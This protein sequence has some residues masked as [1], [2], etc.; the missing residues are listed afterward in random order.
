[1]TSDNSGFFV[2]KE[3]IKNALQNKVV[4]LLIGTSVFMIL[5]R[6][7]LPFLNFS[8][9]ITYSKDIDFHILY[10]GFQNGLIDFYKPIDFENLP[11]GVP[12]W[13][14]YYLYYWYFIFFPVAILPPEIGLYV[15]DILRI[16]F[17]CIV[18]AEA[19]KMFKNKNDRFMFYLLLFI[20][21]LIDVWYNNT[22]FLILF[23]MFLSYRYLEK[24]KF[25]ISGIFFM[26]SMYKVNS[27]LFLPVILL[28]RKVKL[29]QIYYY[30]VPLLIAFI[31]YF[32][33]PD[34]LT[35][36]L[37]NWAYEDE[38]IKALTPIEGILWKALQ[39]SHLV[40]Y[41]F[42]Y[43]VF[44]EGLKEGKNKNRIRIIVLVL[45]ASYYV[46]MIIVTWIIPGNIRV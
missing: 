22:N 7:F 4:L 33:F 30:L 40:Y 17:T 25:W 2:I 46:Y 13:P 43:V 28:T 15:W 38:F 24:E 39:P 9:L 11:E 32:I 5:F 12:N 6:I 35:Q 36:M 29:K 8:Y 14:P 27:L 20:G 44:I 19:P 45:L 16:I 41:G 26:L 37:Q 31:P 34:Y 10:E 23:F 3:Y 42:L 1:V 18:V 21:Y